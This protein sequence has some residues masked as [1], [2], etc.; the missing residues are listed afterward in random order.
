MRQQRSKIVILGAG[1]GG[2]FAA[3]RLQRLLGKVANVEITLVD[4]DNYFVFQPMLPE[5][6]SGDIEVSHILN[7]VR[8]LCP[9]VEFRCC[10]ID[11][12]DLEKREVVTRTG[13][14]L[15]EQRLP[16]DHLLLALGTAVDLTGLPGMAEHALTMKTLGD[17]FFLRNH[18]ISQLEEADEERDQELQRQLLTFA[19][20]GG[21]FSGVETV[22]ALND[23]VRGSLRWYRHLDPRQLR[24]VLLHSRNRLLPELSEGLADFALQKLRGRGIEVWL[25]T[26]VQAAT[27]EAVVLPSGVRIPA[28]SLICTVGS[29]PNPLIA[30]LPCPKDD[31]GRAITDALLEV[32][33]YPGVWAVGDCASVPV[34]GTPEPCPP[35]AQFAIRQGETA[36]A[37]IAAALRG[38]AKRP[39]TYSALGHLSVLGRRSAVAEVFGL[40]LSGFL[41]WWL[42]RTFYL[43]KLPSF[44][45]KLRVAL[46]WTLDLFFPRDIAQLKFHRTEQIA[47]AHYEPGEVIVREGELGDRFYVIVSGEVEVVQADPH[48][49]ETVLAKL[50]RGDYFGEMALLRAGRRTATVRAVTPV[51]VATVRREEFLM[52][53]KSW[54]Q[55]HDD[56][57]QTVRQREAR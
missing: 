4:R 31:H 1:F 16:F 10:E 48:G 52:L 39:F 27:A 29:C 41:A 23:M 51:D 33:G 28:K 54:L 13:T 47:R 50:G 30:A 40:K 37:N 11:G 45:R 21:G 46:D 22:A 15:R 35:T 17:A 32:P 49:G 14:S 36:A 12:I 3:R 18:I 8:R 7:P 56:L 53:A 20:V 34:R 26:R 24:V 42:W 19:V 9:G 57:E 43:M 5:V 55:L 38:G 6:I 2:V 25:N 44:E